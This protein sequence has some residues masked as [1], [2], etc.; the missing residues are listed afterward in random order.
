VYPKVLKSLALQVPVLGRIVRE[1]D[2]LRTEVQTISQERDRFRHAYEKAE[3]EKDDGYCH[4]CRSTTTFEIKGDW[5]RDQ[6]FCLNCFSIPRQRHIQHILDTFFPGWEEKTIHE[7]SPSNKL[8]SQH[9]SAYTFS[10][11]FPGV[12]AGDQVD[13]VRCENLES[14]SFADDSFDIFITQDVLEH[15]FDPAKAV[16]E[17]NRVLK[18]G[19]AH[20]FTAPKHKGVRLSYPRAQLRDGQIGYLMDAEY[21][22]NPVGDGRALVTWDYGDDFE[23]LVGSWSGCPITT[24]ITRDRGLGIDGEYLEVFV[25]RKKAS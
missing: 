4:C 12:K 5:L 2:H 11:Y 7:S 19:G 18:P 17:I 6:Y 22:G 8:V 10:Q 3:V 15:V 24:Y 25:S 1:R 14:L 13:G 9:C 16:K 23:A 21:H 20:V